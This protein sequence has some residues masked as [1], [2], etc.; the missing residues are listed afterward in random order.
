MFHGYQDTKKLPIKTGDVV[1]IKAG[2]RITSTNPSVP[3]R[4]AKRNMKVTVRSMGSGQN[5]TPSCISHYEVDTLRANGFD[6]EIV[7]ATL[8]VYRHECSRLGYNN[9]DF[10]PFSFPIKDPEVCWSGTG[11][12]WCYADINDVL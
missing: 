2:T 5:I 3:E 8:A 9:V 10:T 1:V 7:E 4:I 12:Y 6:D 11:G